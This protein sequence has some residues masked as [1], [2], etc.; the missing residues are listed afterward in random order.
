MIG[1]PSSGWDPVAAFEEAFRRAHRPTSVV[2]PRT[3]ES[4]DRMYAK[5]RGFS[6]Q[7]LTHVWELLRHYDP[8][9]WYDATH[10]IRMDDW[11]EAVYGELSDRGLPAAA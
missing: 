3:R 5:I 1:M 2:G 11:A 7:Q 9:D 8:G 10:G 6:N 4:T